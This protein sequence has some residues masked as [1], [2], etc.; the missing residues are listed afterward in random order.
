MGERPRCRGEERNCS[1]FQTQEG[2]HC[3]WSRGRESER[4]PVVRERWRRPPGLCRVWARRRTASS[5]GW[6][7]G[8]ALGAIQGVLSER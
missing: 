6:G 5:T 2:G 8:E 3:G 7:Q 4:G 1:T